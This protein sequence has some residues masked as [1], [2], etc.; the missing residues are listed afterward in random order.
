MRVKM[1]T[2]MTNGLNNGDEAD[3]EQAEALRL[4]EAGFAV[5]VATKAL[6]KAAKA[7]P[8]ETRPAKKKG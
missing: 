7:S 1:L 4:I 6:E 8:Q 5:P 2:S 3:F